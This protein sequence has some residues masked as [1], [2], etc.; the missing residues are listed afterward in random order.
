MEPGHPRGMAQ[1]SVW[2]PAAKSG[3]GSTS[4][5]PGSYV[6][7]RDTGSTDPQDSAERGSAERGD[8]RN[9]A[10]ADRS[11]APAEEPYYGNRGFGVMASK[12]D[13]FPALSHAVPG[14]D[15]DS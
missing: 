11:P 9:P 7:Y 1:R 8:R 5:P 10:P 6:R 2:R 4:V 14:L 3:S 15:R 13:Y 12:I